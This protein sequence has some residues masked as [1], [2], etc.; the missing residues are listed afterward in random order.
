[1][2]DKGTEK[3]PPALEVCPPWLCFTFDN[4]L[5]KLLQNP[6][7]IL[8][9]YVKQGWTALRCRTWH[10]LFYNPV[11]KISG[12]YGKVI[13]ADLQQPMLDGHST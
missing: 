12:E 8:K 13:A 1:M 11:S 9:P 5:R 3:N 6:D 7:R 10:G 2:N 4:F